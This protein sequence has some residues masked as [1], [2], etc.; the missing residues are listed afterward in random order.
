MKGNITIR[1]RRRLSII[2]FIL[3]FL[4]AVLLPHRVW[5][6]L[7]IGLVGVIAVAYFWVWH[8]SKGLQGSR[9]LRFG[10]M[11]VGDRLSEQFEVRN[12]SGLPALWVEVVDDSNVPGYQAAVVRSI[13]AQDSDRWR[14]S[15]VC[16][17]RGQFKLGPWA[18]KSGDPF[19]IFQVTVGY[20]VSEE[21]IIHPPIHID[22]PIPLPAGQG[23]GRVR[24][25]V[26]PWRS[27]INAAGIRDYN[28]GDPYNWIHWPKSAHFD[29][30]LVRQFDLDSAGDIWLLLDMQETV[31]VGSG[32]EG[33]EEQIILLATALAVRSLNNSRGIGLAAYSQ[34]PKHIPPALGE[35][36]QWRLLR[37]LALIKADGQ[38]D[39]SLAIE[40]LGRV[41]KRSSAA[42]IITS[43]NQSTW[44]PSLVQLVEKGISCTV[45]L[46]DAASYRSKAPGIVDSKVTE[47]TDNTAENLR[48]VIQRLG[49]ECHLIHEG[50]IGR[51]VVEQER[52]GYWEF[53]IT[54]S[55]KAITVRSPLEEAA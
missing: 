10:W 13:N 24:T 25:R 39:L 19:G 26:R 23:E 38:N 40:D 55:G 12:K 1:F 16:E 53:K 18:L 6:T 52:R 3:L 35:G 42:V 27:T 14:Q 11:A 49:L 54:P 45:V 21:I 34:Q 20:P 31:Q 7:L 37:A 22:I 32:P 15:A 30:L 5:N 41:A 51:P 2:W 46:L 17:Q 47:E 43:N 28:P 33:T 29:D 48:Q 36:Q 44:L 8:L 9:H 4:V 50:D